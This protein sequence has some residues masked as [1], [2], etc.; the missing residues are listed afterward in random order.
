MSGSLRWKS[1]IVIDDE[2]SICLAFQRF[3]GDRGWSV[4]SA[5]SAQQGL[6][7]FAQHRTPVVFLDVRLPDQ[8]GLNILEELARSGAKVVVITA[9]G[10]L[11][12]V[13]EAIRG[14]AYDCLVKPLELDEAHVL[15]NRIWDSELD[16]SSSPTYDDSSGRAELIGD[17]PVMQRV[18]KQIARATDS[19]SPVLIEG[20]TGTG[21]EL[22]A[23]AIHQFSRRNDAAFVPVNCGAIPEQLIESDLFGHVRGAFT[24]AERD[25]A[26]RF[27][28]AHG[29]CLMLDEIGD[30]PLP[31]QVKLLRVL[32]DGWIERVGATQPIQVN[33]RVLAVTNKSLAGEVEAGR[34]RRDL[35]YRLAVLH[36]QL[37]PLRDRRGDIPALAERFILDAAAPHGLAPELE[38]AALDL[39]SNYRWP[40]NVRELRNVLRQVVANAPRRRIFA[41]D[42]PALASGATSMASVQDALANAAI[43]FATERED[44]SGA[45]YP[46]ALEVLE[47]ALIGHALKR[48]DGNQSLAADYLGL[49]RNTLRNKLRELKI[50]PSGLPTEKD[51]L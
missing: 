46:R 47:K 19:D 25:R 49:H 28:I 34:F 50:D 7:L 16:A 15:A 11:A 10:A 21:K 41:S 29:G 31:V 2:P 20:E 18:F 48:F 5:S 30:L 39:L 13:V 35:Y 17:S 22:V 32:D 38:P 23:R 24:S 9:Y 43:G 26:G 36:I 27:E 4:F 40:G 6:K 12:T 44:G 37:P 1:M 45:A 14:K 51:K 42:L 8:S 3:F 33:T